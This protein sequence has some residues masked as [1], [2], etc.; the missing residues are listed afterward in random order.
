MANAIIEDYKILGRNE[1]ENTRLRAEAE[2]LVR[3]AREGAEQLER[4]KAAFEQ[5]KQTKA[6]AA[7]ASLKQVRTLAKFLS[8][9]RKS[10]KESISNERKIWK[11]TWAK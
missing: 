2:A 4:E 8:D 7:T 6:W 9:E 5:Y 1:E 3:A 11:E 10:W